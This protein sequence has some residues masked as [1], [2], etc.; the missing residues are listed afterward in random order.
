MKT[1][2]GPSRWVMRAHLALLLSFISLSTAFSAEPTGGGASPDIESVTL[3][4][5]ECYGNC[6]AYS[7]EIFSDRGVRFVGKAHVGKL[8]DQAATI[9]PADFD[10]LVRAVQRLNF[11][12]LGSRYVGRKDGCAETETDAPTIRITVKTRTQRKTV[13]Y[14]LGCYGLSI[15]PKLVWL[16]NTVDEVAGT[17]RWLH[18]DLTEAPKGEPVSTE[19]FSIRHQKAE[20]VADLLMGK[21]CRVLTDSGSAVADRRANVLFVQD[22]QSNMNKIRG[23]INQIDAPGRLRLPE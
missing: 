20:N 3:E 5:T 4:R 7:V 16:A 23:L 17:D 14:Y 8:G 12:G 11:F 13:E 15:R 22:T 9:G 19:T 18:G 10:F 1:I 2:V 6:P 21:G